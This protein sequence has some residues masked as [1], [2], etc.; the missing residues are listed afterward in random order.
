[1]AIDVTTLETQINALIAT[2][3]VDYRVGDKEFK[4]SQKLQQLL[5]LRDYLIANPTAELDI[6]QF[7]TE[8]EDNGQDNTQF[9]V[10]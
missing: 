3:Q 9:T 2:P 1:M 6:V 4:N 8:I 5:K 10:L 7:D